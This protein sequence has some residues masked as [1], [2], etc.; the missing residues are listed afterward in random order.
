M[1]VFVR[2]RSLFD[3]VIMLE[4]KKQT[5]KRFD[6]FRILT[7]SIVMSSDTN[8]TSSTWNTDLICQ[9]NVST[10]STRAK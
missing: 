6:L 1:C 5:N 10:N 9:E 7:R 8:R 2:A 3:C 4:N